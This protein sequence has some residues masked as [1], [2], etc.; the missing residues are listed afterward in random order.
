[1][2]WAR[3]RHCA[4]VIRRGSEAFLESRAWA[5]RSTGI[6]CR[7]QA[8]GRPSPPLFGSH[9][10]EGLSVGP[11]E[12]GQPWTNGLASGS[13]GARAGGYELGHF[14]LAGLAECARHGAYAHVGAGLVPLVGAALA[15]WH[16]RRLVLTQQL[17][18]AAALPVQCK[19]L[20]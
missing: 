12:R 5:V 19:A 6:G 9:V 17:V 16:A 1:M 18:M 15:C 7:G 4:A 14:G 11:T 13:A 8:T 10:D 20:N 2:L 3:D